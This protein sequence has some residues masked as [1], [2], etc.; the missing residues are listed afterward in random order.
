MQS[1]SA[2]LPE[3]LERIV[4]RF[5][6]L[7]EPKQRYEQLILYGQKL[8]EFLAAD[9]L[10]E[11][12]VPGCVSQVYITA[13]LDSANTV[14]YSGDSDALITKGFVGLLILGLNHLSPAEIQNISPEFIKD[15]G[16]TVSLTASRASGFYNVFKTMQQKANQLVVSDS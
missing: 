10:A 15:T 5:Q 12:K 1:T 7:S 14:V 4:K 16:L 6:R 8:P 3:S 13:H 9:K 2:K 11:N